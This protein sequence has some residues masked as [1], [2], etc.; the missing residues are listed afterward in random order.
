[1]QYIKNQLV[2]CRPSRRTENAQKTE[3]GRSGNQATNLGVT[4]LAV[5]ENQLNVSTRF[6]A[7][8]AIDE[9]SVSRGA[10]EM[11]AGEKRERK[12]DKRGK[13][14]ARAV[15][16]SGEQ[17][18]HKENR[19]V[20]DPKEKKLGRVMGAGAREGKKE[21]KVVVRQPMAGA[22]GPWYAGGE[23]FGAKAT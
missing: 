6:N 10:E 7:L 13:E 18:G 22:N 1:M 17:L 16:L 11:I 15:I 9:G 14:V 21:G 23:G 12:G 8:I 3:A 19:A 20:S 2:V 4:S 5:K